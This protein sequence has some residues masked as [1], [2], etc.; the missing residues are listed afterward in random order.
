MTDIAKILVAGARAAYFGPGLD[1]APHHNAT[2]TI[3][4]A[5]SLPFDICIQEHEGGWSDE[6][7]ELIQV[8]PAGTLHHLK[9]RGPMAFFYLDPLSDDHQKLEQ[10]DLVTA[11]NSIL[12]LSE[13]DIASAI[14]I[15]GIP[16]RRITDHKIADIVR[17]IED[18]PQSFETLKGAANAACLSPSRFRA[19]FMQEMGIPFRRYRLWRR[20]AKVMQALSE[21]KNLTEAALLAGFSSSSHLSTA[22]KSM[23]GISPNAVSSMAID[24]REDRN[25]I[26]SI[27]RCSE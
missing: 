13:P 24:C 21:S 10:A 3:A 6:Y 9:A 4:I 26:Q 12:T 23:F 20:M 16:E 11:R 14:K 22:F 19:R 25:F 15:L 18:Q 17:L 27:T 2:T 8:I 1:L 5:L 7:S